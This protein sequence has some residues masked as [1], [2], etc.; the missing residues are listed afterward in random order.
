[1]IIYISMCFCTWHG[2]AN[3]VSRLYSLLKSQYFTVVTRKSVYSSLH[4]R[5]AGVH[6]RVTNS[7][8]WTVTTTIS[9]LGVCRLTH[10]AYL[11]SSWVTEYTHTCRDRPW[12]ISCS[13]HVSREPTSPI[14]D[15]Y[16]SSY[17]SSQDQ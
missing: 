5:A 16:L 2:F 15:I 7:T 1:M 11:Q 14:H 8:T 13:Q 9:D 3:I 12:H 10:R 17:I 6:D 4:Y